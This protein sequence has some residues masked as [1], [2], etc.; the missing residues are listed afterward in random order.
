MPKVLHIR[1]ARSGLETTYKDWAEWRKRRFA[2]DEP[3]IWKPCPMCWQQ[4]RIIHEGAWHLCNTCLG[5][6]STI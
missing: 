6:G 5:V 4:G 1:D 2:V 3:V